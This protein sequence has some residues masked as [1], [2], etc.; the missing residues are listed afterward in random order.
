[1]RLPFKTVP[2]GCEQ[3]SGASRLV[4]TAVLYF[5]LDKKAD[6]EEENLTEKFSD[7]GAW[8]S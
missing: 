7:Y 5:V 1:M 3:D 8:S 4:L 2:Q 6:L